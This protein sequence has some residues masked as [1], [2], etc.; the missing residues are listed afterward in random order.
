MT[1]APRA[2]QPVPVP[3]R[4]ALEGADTSP[5]TTGVET[6]DAPRDGKRWLWPLVAT[7][8]AALAVVGIAAIRIT[9]GTPPTTMAPQATATAP[10]VSANPVPVMLVTSAPT[11]RAEPVVT[12]SASASQKAT[13]RSTGTARTPRAKSSRPAVLDSPY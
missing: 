11:T 12:A 4:A 1:T 3:L 8:A 13:P 10:S 2:F 6:I 7:V 9:T 5:V